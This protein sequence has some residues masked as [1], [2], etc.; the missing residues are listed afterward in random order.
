LVAPDFK[1]PGPAKRTFCWRI[2][3]EKKLTFG[4][5]LS[6]KKTTFGWGG[7]QGKKKIV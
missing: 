3:G 2:S 5:E 6:E 1:S 7:L 4:G